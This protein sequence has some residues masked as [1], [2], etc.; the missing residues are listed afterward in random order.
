MTDAEREV[1]DASVAYAQAKRDNAFSKLDDASRR[2][3]LRALWA[4]RKRW[5][6][7]VRLYSGVAPWDDADVAPSSD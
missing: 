3:A 2:E 6:K 7:A 4:A 5:A 1:L